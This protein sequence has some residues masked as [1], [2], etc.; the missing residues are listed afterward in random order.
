MNTA[1]NGN[2]KMVIDGRTGSRLECVCEFTPPTPAKSGWYPGL[3]IHLNPVV[4]NIKD[5][6]D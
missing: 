2:I 4:N 5:E 1:N 3:H 6:E